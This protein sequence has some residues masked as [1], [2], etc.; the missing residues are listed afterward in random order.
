MEQHYQQWSE[1]AP[2]GMLL[3]GAGAS[4]M[5]WAASMRG[6]RKPTLLWI[7]SGLFGLIILNTGVAFFGEGMKH[8]A[9]QLVHRVGLHLHDGTT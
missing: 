4:L 2:R 3:I 7:L 8:R 5:A 1:M 6:R 9:L